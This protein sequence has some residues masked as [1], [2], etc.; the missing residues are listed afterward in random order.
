MDPNKIKEIINDSK[1]QSNI[2]LIECMDFLSNEHEKLKDT[3][4][5][6]TYHLDEVEF[7]YNKI[8]EEYKN[9]TK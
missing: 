6:L 1:N 4:L 8:L 7:S 2:D 5:K 9:R 3:I